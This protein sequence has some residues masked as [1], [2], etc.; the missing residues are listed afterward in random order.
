MEKVE[1]TNTEQE[2]IV[3]E[4]RQ[5]TI[6]DG[7]VFYIKP[8]SSDN[9][10]KADLHYSKVYSRCLV[11]DIFTAAEI[12]DALKR[13][14]LAG[15]EYETRAADLETKIS[16]KL[17]ELN[18]ATDR[19]SKQALAREVEET[20][21]EIFQWNQRING[22]MS[23][24]CEQISD[25]ARIEYLTS[26]MTFDKDGK[27]VWTD[28][29]AYLNDEDKTL[30]FKARFEL[31]LYMQGLPSD[32]LDNTPE[33]KAMREVQEE[34]LEEINDSLNKV[35]A[36]DVDKPDEKMESVSNELEKPEKPAKKRAA[37]SK[38]KKVSVDK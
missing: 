38:A 20:R 24:T 19:D 37:K 29:E 2:N 30:T 25:D 4:E 31:M 16:V 5:F 3:S 34:M 23:N 10:R 32:F 21:E 7:K 36:E 1:Q 11:E 8:A 9:I 17:A 28:Y 18:S 27:R 6:L 26:C 14:G 12:M 35:E 33:R 15:P 13:K 22:P